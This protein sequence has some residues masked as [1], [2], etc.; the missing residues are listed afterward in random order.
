MNDTRLTFSVTF[1]HSFMSLEISTRGDAECGHFQASGII[2]DCHTDRHVS[3]V[4]SF[5]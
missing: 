2:C 3:F 4:L 1:I 5:D